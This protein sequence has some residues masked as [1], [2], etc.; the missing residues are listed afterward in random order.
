MLGWGR[1]QRESERERDCIAAYIERRLIGLGRFLLSSHAVLVE[2]R[3]GDCA[4][5]EAV[6]EMAL[7]MEGMELLLGLG[8]WMKL[9]QRQQREMARL[10]VVVVV[11]V[12]VVELLRVQVVRR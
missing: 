5:G 2:A 6:H 3:H 4:A 9:R 1:R 12:V 10:Q 8:T 11:L 7:E